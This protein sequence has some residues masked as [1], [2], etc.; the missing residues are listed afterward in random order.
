M[1]TEGID[2]LNAMILK[3]NQLEEFVEEV[4]PEI[5]TDL[6][7][8]LHKTIAAGTSFG[9]VPWT[10]KKDGSKPLSNAASALEVQAVGSVVVAMLNGV[11][12]RHH[13]G[14]VRGN[15]GGN[16]LQRP[17]LPTKKSLG[18]VSNVV[19]KTLKKRFKE[20]MEG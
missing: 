19:K 5:A 12:A 1:A 7:K 13:K 16:T 8:E 17:I 20:I 2:R 14:A 3:L 11:E 18:K 4:T 9:G 10:P 6:E 15:K